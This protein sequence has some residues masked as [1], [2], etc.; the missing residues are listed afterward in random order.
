MIRRPPRSTQSRS[1]AASDVYKRQALGRALP[2]G[3]TPAED[4]VDLLAAACDP[5]LV[6]MPSGRFFGFV[7]GGAQPAALAA[8][9]L[10][11]AWDQNAILRKVTPAAAAV[12]EVAAAWLLDLLDLPS[13]SGVGFVTGATMANFTG[14]AAARDELLR[15]AAS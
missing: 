15:A 6:A 7:I 4:V 5:G 10:V 12:E 8:D 11:S 2:E 14:L 9:W 13:G 1:S 3:P